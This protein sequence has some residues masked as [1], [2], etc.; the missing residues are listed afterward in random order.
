MLRIYGP[1]HVNT[2]YFLEH[3]DRMVRAWNQQRRNLVLAFIARISTLGGGHFIMNTMEDKEQNRKRLRTLKKPL[4][5]NRYFTSIRRFFLKVQGLNF[6]LF[7]CHRLR[8][9]L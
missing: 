8:K 9:Y 2:K 3:E 7:L 4:F 1:S 5:R 6:A